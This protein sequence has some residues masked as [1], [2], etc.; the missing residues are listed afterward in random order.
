[1]AK[2]FT[3]PFAQRYEQR[4]G[5]HNIH[6]ARVL[7]AHVSAIFGR[8]YTNQRGA[9]RSCRYSCRAQRVHRFGVFGLRAA[10]GVWF[11]SRL[12]DRHRLSDEEL[13]PV[14]G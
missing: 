10:G 3:A 6:A 12:H 2:T 4:H 14:G 5:A 13:V 7:E 9:A 11:L 1:M 8:K